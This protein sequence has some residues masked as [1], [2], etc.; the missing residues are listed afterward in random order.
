VK[1]LPQFKVRKQEDVVEF[2]TRVL[3]QPNKP[4]VSYFRRLVEYEDGHYGVEFSLGYFISTEVPTK[5]QW[6]SLKKKLKRRDKKVFVFKKH[7]VILC[8]ASAWCGFLEFGFFA[9]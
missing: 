1:D 7:N 3:T 6:N 4:E 9:H 8:D 5:S 2:I